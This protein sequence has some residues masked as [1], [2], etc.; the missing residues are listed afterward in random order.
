MGLAIVEI[1]DKSTQ[2]SNPHPVLYR[3]G[4]RVLDKLNNENQKIKDKIYNMRKSA[5]EK[6]TKRK[7]KKKINKE[8]DEMAMETD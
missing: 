6:E 2:D 8:K 1:I 4:W 7:Y 3:L 5:Y